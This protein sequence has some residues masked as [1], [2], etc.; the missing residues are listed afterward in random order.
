MLS[1]KIA[2]KKFIAFSSLI[3]Y[4]SYFVFVQLRDNFTYD[5]YLFANNCA[6]LDKHECNY[7]SYP[8]T[9][10]QKDVGSSW[11][12]FKTTANLQWNIKFV[13]VFLPSVCNNN[14]SRLYTHINTYK[15]IQFL[16]EIKNF[17]VRCIVI[18]WD[19]ATVL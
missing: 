6:L 8:R 5:I 13:F 19:H 11:Q 15:N 17:L 7:L 16:I 4:W 14:Y 3:C 1:E 2:S 10:C 12:S 18:S 9:C